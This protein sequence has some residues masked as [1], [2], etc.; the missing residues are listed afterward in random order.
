MMTFL[1]IRH[2]AHLLGGDKIAGRSDV[3]LSPLGREQAAATARR[4]KDVP[5]RAI[6]SSP[7]MRTRESAAPL[8]ELLGLPVQLSDAL[9]EIDYGE[10]SGRTLDTLRPLAR[11]GHWNSF[12]SGTR[13]PN[14]ELML[15]VQSRIVQE[16]LRLRELH[17]N[18][19]VALFSHGDVIRAALAYFLGIPLDMFQR[20][21][22]SLSSIS[23]VAL[24][25]GGPWV[26]GV[27]CTEKLLL[28]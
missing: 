8:S 21:E 12:R 7:V 10:W 1:L 26:L 15:Q 20:F 3:Q 19:T 2:G 6:Y 5:I 4:L 27:N 24:G 17:V 16:M 23:V 13:V 11:W 14:G 28:P 25:D 22:I 18:E 9:S